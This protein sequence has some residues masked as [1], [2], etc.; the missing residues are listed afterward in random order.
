MTEKMC[1][2]CSRDEHPKGIF[3]SPDYHEAI[4]VEL[5]KQ[6][7]QDIFGFTTYTC[8]KC[9]YSQFFKEKSISFKEI[10]K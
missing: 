4:N 8:P 10:K 6:R 9:G 7:L 2:Y 1:P 3:G 5:K